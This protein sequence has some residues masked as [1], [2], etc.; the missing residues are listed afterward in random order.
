MRT[1]TQDNTDNARGSGESSRPE[2]RYLAIGQILR[3]HG[4]RGELK[5]KLL[6][7]YPERLRLHKHI[8]LAPAHSPESVRQYVVEQMRVHQD[9]MLLKLTGCDERNSADELRGMLVQIPSSD[10]VPLDEGEYYTYQVE[11]L[12]V[13]TD[14]GDVL[15]KVVE[16]IETGANDV[17]VVRGPYGEVLL[18][19]VTDVILDLN[20]ETGRMLVHLL[21]GLLDEDKR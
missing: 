1:D 8:Y 7:N 21:P 2:P 19:A 11:G 3:P 16:V 12:V 17:Y 6:T 18:P 13:E 20:M 15:G 14:T 9:V 4:V 10:A 5:A